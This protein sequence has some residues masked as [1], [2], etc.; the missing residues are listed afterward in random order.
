[1][2]MIDRRA[3]M[4]ALPI[5]LLLVDSTEAT[6]Q[7]RHAAHGA[8]F[9]WDGTWHGNWGEQESQATSVTILNNYVVSFEYHGVSTPVSASTV[10]ARTVS[11]GYDGVWVIMTRTSA[12]TAVASLHSPLGDATARLT[13]Q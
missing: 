13:K 12:T 10:T 2:M 5:S 4:A 7:G 1:M 8:K 3:V 9:S 11:Y 6:A